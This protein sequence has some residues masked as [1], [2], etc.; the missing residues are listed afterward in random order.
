MSRRIKIQEFYFDLTRSLF[1]FLALSLPTLNYK[2]HTFAGNLYCTEVILCDQFE[3]HS[4]RSSNRS[5]FKMGHV[6]VMTGQQFDL[7]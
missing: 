4:N 2:A 6:T 3:S 5:W 7:C 1:V